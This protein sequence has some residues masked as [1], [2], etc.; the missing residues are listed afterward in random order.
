[1]H[2]GFLLSER[3]RIEHRLG[4]GGMADVYLAT[5]TYLNRQVAIKVLRLDFRDDQKA[6]QRFRHE[7]AA[8][9][10]LNNS[11]I[12]GV[13]D[14]GDTEGMQYIVMEF[15]DGQ[16]LKQYIKQNF[17]I[18]YAKVVDIMEQ[19]FVAVKEAHDHNII[20]RDLKPQ[21]ILIDKQGYVKITDF[22]ISKAESENTMTQTRSIVG[23]IHYLSPE[24]IKG[25]IANQQSDIYSLGIILYE[26]LTGKVPFNGETAVSIAIKHSQN[27][28][29]SVRDFDPRIPQA[30][31]NV[32]LK[33]TTKNPVNRYDNVS[34]MAQDLQTA[35]DQSRA[36]EARFSI[37]S[38]EAATE[39]TK[40]MPFKPLTAANLKT[41]DGKQNKRN[42]SKS[43]PK[44]RKHH[45]RRWI[46][47]SILVLLVLLTTALAAIGSRTTVPSVVGLSQQAAIEQLQKS[48]LM[49][50][51]ITYQA[52]DEITKNKVITTDPKANTK[53]SKQAKIKLIVSAGP[54]KFQL[55]NYVG[56]DYQMTADKLEAKGFNV[57]KRNASSETFQ[58]GQILQQ[59]FKA[60]DSMVPKGSTLTFVVSTGISQVTLANLHGMTKNQVISYMNKNGLNP[61]FD[62]VYSNKTKKNRVDHQSPAAGQTIRQGSS[63]I[64]YLSRGKREQQDELHQF[65]VRIKI[66]FDHQT[67]GQ[68]NQSIPTKMAYTKNAEESDDYEQSSGS[69]V[70]D[71]SS[72]DEIED[73]QSSNIILIYLKDHD[74]KYKN[75]YKQMIITKDSAIT[76]P[77][78]L[79]KNEVGKYKIVRNDKTIIE[80]S[81]VTVDSH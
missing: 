29:P 42:K 19:V 22:G 58:A 67:D 28:I 10:E 32:V 24:Q 15:V 73:G 47:I 56:Q 26:M 5:D 60:G 14:F 59:D 1:M 4:E 81:N 66:P 27:P 50:G 36:N 30:L 34:E 38:A 65:N 35:L 20:H 48:D 71:D 51:K 16:N 23:S 75:V 70:R 18:P 13:Y 63:V 11:H 39:E 53:V 43:V 21:N 3:Y 69:D 49:A 72:S 46:I 74:H 55:E 68:S 12:V 45:R 9:S 37:N 6:Q 79:T 40:V 7:A 52:S 2:N 17:P 62:Y 54:K 31:E 41:S 61:V 78:K 80:D 57:K 44:R 8:I 76:L 64:V 33:A 77:F 25:H